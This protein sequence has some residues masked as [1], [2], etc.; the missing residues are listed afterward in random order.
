MNKRENIV[1]NMDR[2]MVVIYLLLLFMGWANIYSAA[3]SADHP[4]LF[5][6]SMEYGNQSVWI[7]ICLVMGSALMMVRGDFIKDMAI[8]AYAFVLL[9]LVLVPLIG[10]EIGGNKNWLQIGPVR[11][12]PSEFAKFTTALVLTHYLSGLKSF[13]GLRSR[14]TATLII[15][16]PV[17][18]IL[19]GKDVGT[20]LTFGAFI[21]V[22]YRE[23]LSGNILLLAIG[24]L[25][26]AILSL[27]LRETMFHIPFVDKPVT[28]QYFLIG[29]IGLACLLAFY[30]VS[31]FVL[32]RLRRR[33]YGFIAF[34]LIGSAVF[35]SG[36]DF[37]F[38]NLL[39]ERHRTRI[40]VTLGL[41]D[42]PQGLGYNA[43]Q[44]KTAIGSGGLIGK[45]YLQGTFTKYK[46]VPEQQTDFIFCTVGEEWGFLGTTLIVALFGALILR[47]IQ[48]GERQRSRFTRIYAYCVAS[49][50]FLH[51]M[52]NV[53]MAIGLA[54]V[55]GIPLPFF[56]YGGSSLI[57][58]TI[59]LGILVRMDAERL[60][61]LR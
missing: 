18:L 23:G 46:Y 48:V 10:T 37:V 39:S 36:F 52:I 40:N 44:S 34:T 31:R 26:L 1:A 11:I 58:F 35:I 56:S 14:L 9:L 20:A 2:P 55:I 16:A 12:Q 41:L 51:L 50:F 22:L 28:G 4:N 30:V 27:I 32:K 38:Q 61:Q 54:P 25:I 57:S 15:V 53:G 19:L 59:L 3:Y 45:G 8:P 43:A 6:T 47:C 49:I 7:V 21:L 42:D 17:G 33:L 29:L 5:D 60:S 24:V 13:S